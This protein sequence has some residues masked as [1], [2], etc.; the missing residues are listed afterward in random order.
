MM[1]V[2]AFRERGLHLESLK[3]PAGTLAKRRIVVHMCDKCEAL[4]CLFDSCVSS[5]LIEGPHDSKKIMCL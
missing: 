3:E 1:L 2:N 4:Q 5:I